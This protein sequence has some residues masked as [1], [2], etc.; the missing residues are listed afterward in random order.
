MVKTYKLIAQI[1]SGTIQTSSTGKQFNPCACKQNIDINIM[2]MNFNEFLLHRATQPNCA[3]LTFLGNFRFGE[4]GTSRSRT[5][6][7]KKISESTW[8]IEE[9]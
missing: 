7:P 3:G 6:G 5:R 2:T 8:H 1:R 9:N 4:Q